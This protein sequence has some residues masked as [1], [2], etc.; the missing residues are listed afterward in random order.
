MYIM[1]SVDAAMSGVAKRWG[2]WSAL[3]MLGLLLISPIL[4]IGY[5]LAEWGSE[6]GSRSGTSAL[7]VAGVL[8]CLQFPLALAALP[9]LFRHRLWAWGLAAAARVVALFA[10]LFTL[11][12]DGT[13][14]VF[15]AAG[16]YTALQACKIGILVRGRPQYRQSPH[17]Q[18]H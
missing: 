10:G 7:R 1:R 4:Y 6:F 5:G 18:S 13:T 8:Y 17:A 14:S 9:G 16:A 12:D 3:A 2:L 15:I 11:F